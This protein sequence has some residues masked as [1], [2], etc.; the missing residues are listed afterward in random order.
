MTRALRHSAEEHRLPHA[1]LLHG[2]LHHL[3]PHDPRE[4]LSGEHLPP[5]VAQ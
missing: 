5:P 4:P 2:P 3:E 1:H